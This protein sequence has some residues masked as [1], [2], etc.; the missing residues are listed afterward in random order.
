MLN[1]GLFVVLVVW[2]DILRYCLVGEVDG[3]LVMF[4]N[5]GHVGVCVEGLAFILQIMWA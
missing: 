4:V 2:S 5:V 3:Y 1:V